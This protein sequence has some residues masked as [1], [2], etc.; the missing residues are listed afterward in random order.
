[1]KNMKSNIDDLEKRGFVHENEVKAADFK[2]MTSLIE[3]LKSSTAIERTK[4]AILIQKKHLGELIPELITALSTESK[5]YSKI[6]ISNALISF[7]ESSIRPLI[8]QLGKIGK[9]QHKTLPVKP[10][11]KDSYPLPRDIIARILVHIRG[12][13]I[14]E[15]ITAELSHIQLPEAVDVLGHISFYTNDCEALPYLMKCYS[16]K[17]NDKI[18]MWKIIRAFSAFNN[19]E[20]TSL[21]KNVIK[22][23][24][25][26]EMVWEAERS[27]RIIKAREELLF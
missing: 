27:V 19:E 22:N 24:T 23:S 11:N 7:K 4:A 16:E 8:P 1:L 25:L 17:H 26:K 5:L 15:I 12:S 14:S 21:L 6:E 13:V 9:N 10:F 18:I 3:Q 2:S 20:I